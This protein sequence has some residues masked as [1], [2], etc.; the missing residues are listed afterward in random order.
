MSHSSKF[1][2]MTGQTIGDWTVLRYDGVKCNVAYWMCQCV[3]G[4]TRSVNGQFLRNGRTTSCGCRHRPGLARDNHRLH[5]IW[6][7]MK[8]RCQNPNR[9]YYES[10]GGKGIRVCHEWQEFPAFYEWAMA[11]GYSDELTIDRI[12]V[13][14]NYEPSNCQWITKSE[15]SKK[16]AKDRRRK[17]N[18]I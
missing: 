3:C 12:D 14:G 13:D 11:N 15:N 4:N 2:D 1:I 6:T 17:K 16:A 18:G 5:T 7:N 10:Y 8:S 9:Q